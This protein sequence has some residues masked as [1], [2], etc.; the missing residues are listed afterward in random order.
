MKIKF[1]VAAALSMLMFSCK[2]QLSSPSYEM[3]GSISPEVLDNYLSRAITQGEF[4]LA[5]TEVDFQENLR[6]LKNIGAKY[7]GRAAFEWT[8][9]MDNEEHFAR[10]ARYAKMAHEADPDFMLQCCIFEAIFHSNNQLT[11]YGLDLIPVPDWVFEE[12]G[13]QPQERN[14]NYEAMLYQDG[15]YVDHW[16]RGASVPDITQME[17]QM[18]FFYRAARY[19]DCGIESIHLGQVELMNLND[20][21]NNTWFDLVDRIRKYAKKHARRHYVLFDGHVPTHGIV[22]PDGHLLFDFHSF[23]LRPV[24]KGT[25]PYETE[26]RPGHT[27]SLILKS[28]G[29][30]TPSGW[31]CESLPYLLEFDNSGCDK[32]YQGKLDH[33]TAIWPWG[34]DEITWFAHCSKEYRDWWLEYATDW[35]KENDPAGH[36]QVPGRITIAADPIVKDGRKIYSYRLNNPSPTCPDGFGQ[37]DKVKELWAR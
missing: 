8:P 9:S 10:V 28:K 31:T 18:Y 12:F 11:K 25:T 4:L 27:N 33:P 24:E 17:T 32:G 37:E 26:L 30:I 14:F 20:P 19:I 5:P 15:R 1:L 13:L 29:G 2:D 16:V 22:S 34:W 35:L 36:C 7:I 21:S 6:M 3:D 23:P